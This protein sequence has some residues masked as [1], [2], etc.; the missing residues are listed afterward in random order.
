MIALTSSLPGKETE[1]HDC[2]QR[3]H[4]P[5]MVSFNGVEGA[6]RFEL[7]AKLTGTDSNHYLAV[8][9]IDADLYGTVCR[10]RSASPVCKLSRLLGRPIF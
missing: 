2:Y 6:Q 4:L 7:V 3:T 1:F 8:Y 10:M 5:G 9:D